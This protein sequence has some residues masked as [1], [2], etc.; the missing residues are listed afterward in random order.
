ML[1]QPKLLPC[2]HTFCHR[3]LEKFVNPKLLVECPICRK[4]ASNTFRFWKVFGWPQNLTQGDPAERAWCCFTPRQYC[5]QE[6]GWLQMFMQ[7]A[8]GQ[9]HGKLQILLSS[10]FSAVGAWWSRHW[11]RRRRRYWDGGGGQ[12]EQVGQEQ[13]CRP[14]WAA[15]DELC[16]AEEV[17]S[18]GLGC[19]LCWPRW[20]T[21]R[22]G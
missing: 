4:V 5:T 10:I 6:T 19:K 14:Q 11:R 9:S 17:L 2:G 22:W 15:Q 16:Q 1:T 8:T 7:L 21:G 20:T 12:Q 3:C 13:G 18:V